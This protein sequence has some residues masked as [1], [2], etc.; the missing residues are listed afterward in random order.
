MLLQV[1]GFDDLSD[2]AMRSVASSSNRATGD[3]DRR[4]AHPHM[5]NLVYGRRSDPAFA[6]DR[7]SGALCR[8]VLNRC[9]KWQRQVDSESG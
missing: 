7:L 9:A 8:K 1:A 3:V 5:N 6:S 2:A 4:A